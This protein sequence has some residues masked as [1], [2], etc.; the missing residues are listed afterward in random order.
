M[1]DIE[2]LRTALA[3]A[4]HI[5]ASLSQRLREHELVLSGLNALQDH[6]DPNELIARAF[7]LLR[8]SVDFVDAL[9]LTPCSE[10]F[11]CQASTNPAAMGCVWP[12][13]GFFSRVAE[14]RATVVPSNAL[15]PEWASCTGYIPPSGGAVYAPVFAHGGRGLLILTDHEHGAYSATDA[16]LVSKLG[17]LI[18]QSLA[19]GERR[20]LA[21]AFQ[22]ADVERLAAVEANEAKTRFI[23]NMSHEIRTPLNGVLAVADLLAR[24]PL[25]QRQAEMTQMIVE[26]GRSLERLLSDVLDISRIEAG[27]LA[28]ESQPFDLVGSL[29]ATLQ[30]FAA[31]AGDKGLFFEVAVDPSALG[32]FEGDQLRVGQIVANLVNN[33]VK[34]TQRGAISVGIRADQNMPSRIEITVHDTG[35]GFSEEAATRLFGR[36]EQADQSITKQYGGTGLGLS[37]SK[38]LAQMMGGEI[39]ATGAEGVGSKF[40][41]HFSAARVELEPEQSILSL[42]VRH[43]QRP[44]ILVVEDNPNNRRIAGMI[45]EIINAEVTY[46]ENGQLGVDLFAQEAFDAVLMDMQMP[47][48]D[49]LDA[50]R[51]MRRWEG[52]HGRMPVPIIMLSANTMPHHLSESM[53]AGATT[54][55]AK[56]I[57]PT[58]LIE[59]LTALLESQ[60][61]NVDARIAKI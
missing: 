51:A 39:T 4:K 33:A 26:S 3:S 47:I 8:Q 7:L 58:L 28:I 12:V 54:H 52:G 36:F 32:G 9:V 41:F 11:A 50:T 2:H 22:T 17:L 57:Q 15:V 38:A 29:N 21:Q 5:E 46:A 20:R 31:K 23:A 25:N 35:C 1:D 10:G 24:T 34:F 60:T 40:T 61:F 55:V 30:L 56:P 37:I 27:R 49:G 6:V 44:R 48:M 59:T 45:L 13:G 14:G 19:A 18:S 43:A 42:D 53:A 16:H